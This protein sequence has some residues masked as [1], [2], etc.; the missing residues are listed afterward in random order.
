MK[1]KKIGTLLLPLI[2]VACG[3]GLPRDVMP[4]DKMQEVL[5]DIAQGSEFVNGY[6]YYRY[7]DLNRAAINQKVLNQVF[8]IHKISKKE[9]DKSLEY[10]Q[11]K[12]DLFVALMDSIITRNEREKEKLRE[13]TI[14]SDSTTIPGP[15]AKL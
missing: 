1:R 2:L 4:K 8:T 6:V 14:P 12:P 3:L 15:P 10:Y 11:S 5:W 13:P 7:P 9:F